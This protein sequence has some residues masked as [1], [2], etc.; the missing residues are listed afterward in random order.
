MNIIPR[1]FYLDDLFDSFLDSE[2]RKMTCDIYEKDGNYHLE[3]DIP[4][5]SKED[6]KIHCDNGNL[7][8]TAEKEKE[9]KEEDKKYIRR[10]RS[11]GK[12]SRSFYLGNIDED[13]INAE[14]KNGTL[15][16]TIPKVSEIE[17]KKMIEIK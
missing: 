9:E 12:Y 13:N 11:Y 17:S 3:M 5:F 4:G 7:T 10:E 16:I 6:I 14:F 8:V 2:S 15:T 1:K